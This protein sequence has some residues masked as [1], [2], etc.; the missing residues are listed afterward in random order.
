MQSQQNERQVQSALSQD[1]L[2][3][4]ALITPTLTPTPTP[5]LL[6]HRQGRFLVTVLPCVV[7]IVSW[8]EFTMNSM[9]LCSLLSACHRGSG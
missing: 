8:K 2:L 4:V 1:P 3:A 9:C 6:T 7:K 5:T